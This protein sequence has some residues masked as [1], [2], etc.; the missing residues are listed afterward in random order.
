MLKLSQFTKRAIT[1]ASGTAASQFLMIAFAPVLTRIY[2]PENFGIYALFLSIQNVFSVFVT[3]KYE[4]SVL[5]E[6]KDEDAWYNVLLITTIAFFSSALLIVL[7][8]I[9]Y[10]IF[11]AFKVPYFQLHFTFLIGFSLLLAGLYQGFYFW[12]NRNNDYSLLTRNRLYGAVSVVSIS[13]LCGVYGAKEDGLILGLIA[14]QLVNTLLLYTKLRKIRNF[15]MPW[16]EIKRQAIIHINFPKFLV[17]SGLLDRASAQ[18]HIMLFSHL[19]GSFVTGN[20]GLYQRI[21]ALPVNLVGISV[22]NVFRQQACEDL[23]ANGHCRPLFMSTIWKLLSIGIVPFFLLLFFA[24]DF[25]QFVFGAQWKGAGQYAQIMS[26]MF[27]LGFVVSP[28][29]SLIYIGKYQKYDLILQAFLLT[30][31]VIS[32]WIGYKASS[33]ILAIT[34]YTCSYCVKYLVELFISYKLTTDVA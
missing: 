23:N 1:L 18:S 27:L 16:A 24:P 30:S 17:P 21:V 5:I 31:T 6:E 34:L 2:S 33:V 8:F 12:F 25:F 4:Y 28:I 10:L 32:I 26:F 7:G 11:N 19:F 13:I 29:S 3:G 9:I 15:L 14:G 22:A 20:L